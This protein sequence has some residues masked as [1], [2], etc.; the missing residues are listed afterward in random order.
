MLGYVFASLWIWLHAILSDCVHYDFGVNKKK[1]T[2]ASV[3]IQNGT[4]S[5]YVS[6]WWPGHKRNIKNCNGTQC[7]E[8]ISLFK[9]GHAITEA[10]RPRVFT[11][12]TWIQS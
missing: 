9:E 11:V 10:F 12:E 4:E 6:I 5:T 1:R 2:S 8:N 3:T 7:V